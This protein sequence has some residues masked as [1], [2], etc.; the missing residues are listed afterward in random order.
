VGAGARASLVRRPEQA[1]RL[2]ADLHHDDALADAGVQDVALL[3]DQ[4]RPGQAHLDTTGLQRLDQDVRDDV[5]GGGAGA[6]AVEPDVGAAAGGERVDDARPGETRDR[7]DDAGAL[8]VDEGVDL[9]AGDLGGVGTGDVDVD[10]EVLAG[11][12]DGRRRDRDPRRRRFRQGGGRE[13]ERREYHRGR[14]DWG[15]RA[16][17]LFLPSTTTAIPRPR[18]DGPGAG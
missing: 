3:V 16:H 5:G 6:A 15:F 17:L 10:G 7:G 9:E 4:D 14:C 2:A 12:R 1:L 18:T 11:A 8:G 13:R